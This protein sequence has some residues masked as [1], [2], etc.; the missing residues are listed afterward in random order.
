MPKTIGIVGSRRRNSM[1]DLLLVRAAVHKIYEPGDRFV[2]GGCPQ[3]GDH[4]A[5]IL[6]QTLGATITIHF[7]DWNQYGKRAGLVR[8]T[9]IAQDA[10]VLVACV[11]LDR[12]GGTED[13]IKK[14]SKLGKTQL[15]L[16]EQRPT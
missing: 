4:F 16:V 3:G 11:A 13:T 14:Y 5:L 1:Q 10:D 9:L 6:A 2:S 15:V 7:P 8:N 12:R